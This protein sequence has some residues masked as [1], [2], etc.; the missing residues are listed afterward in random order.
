MQTKRSIIIYLVMSLTLVCGWL[1]LFRDNPAMR[2]IGVSVFPILW[3]ILSFLWT[4][5]A[6]RMIKGRKKYVWLFIS[7]GV[8]F[9]I[10]SNTY[11]ISHFIMTGEYL[12]PIISYILWLFTYIFFFI[13]LIYKA[14]LLSL[15]VSHKPYVFNIV[16]FMIMTTSI[17]SHYLIRPILVTSDYSVGLAIINLFYPV[18]SLGIIFTTTYIYYL[19]KRTHE[20]ETILFI[21][22]SF[23]FQAGA[24]WGYAYIVLTQGDYIPGGLMDPLWLVSIMLIGLAGLKA[25]ENAGS[26]VLEI[27]DEIKPEYTLFPYLSVLFLAVLV[28]QS[29][30]W[31]FNLLSVGVTIVFFTI[32]GRQ[33]VII[34]QNEQ[35]MKEYKHLAYHDPLTGLK[36][37]VSFQEEIERYLAHSER[38]HTGTVLMLI[39]LDRFKA[40]N[41][42][43]GHHIGDEVLIRAGN[44]LNTGLNAH[45]VY[46]LGGD[47]FVFILSGVDQETYIQL[48]EKVIHLFTVPFHVKGHE[49]SVTPS[50]GISMY[51]E[52]GNDSASLLKN[53]DA[54][55]YLAKAN[56]SNQ[57]CVYNAELALAHERKIRV[58]N[59]LRKAV[60]TEQLFLVYQPIVE[61]ETG[62]PIGMEAL[63]RWVH[64]ELGF[65]SPAEFIPIA[66]ETGQIVCIGEWVL[67]KACE[68]T[69]RWHDEGYA[70]LYVSVNVSARQI[71][72]GSFVHLVQTTLQKTGLSVEKLELEITESIM[73][74]PSRSTKV[75]NDLQ[76][77]GVKTAID[78]FG[79]GYSSLYLLKELPINTIKIDKAFVDDMTNNKG[80]SVV[81]SIIQIG[82][83]LGL[84]IIA[85][86]IEHETQAEELLQDGCHYG[87]G[88]HYLKPAKVTEFSTYLIKVEVEESLS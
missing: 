34:K 57:Y 74:D 46:R 63:L 50:I 26:P 19:S 69:K 62:R 35:L 58:E 29:Y 31:S 47:E 9:Y 81:K 28:A 6:Y 54:A 78:D 23:I 30:D 21:V 24:D 70:Y 11:W 41:D 36:N 60:E 37:R 17:I 85:E 32:I 84:K 5:N 80:H 52:N 82:R 55:M 61:L 8:I 67:R 3:G 22:L 73:Q 71:Q 39:D 88:Y 45:R 48:A 15:A 64:P 83:N 27:N 4:F 87:Q 33:F 49:M 86:G 12:F 66:E 2:T 25:K 1:Y 59:E 79:T 77:L 68:Q 7:I 43:L 16:I 38:H 56:G 44:R 14:W 10:L 51:P 72:Q 42:T 40:I 13:G 53:A 76:H 75:L 65:V 20:K 18:A